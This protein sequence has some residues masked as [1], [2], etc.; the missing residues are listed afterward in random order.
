MQREGECNSLKDQAVPS[1]STATTFGDKA[2]G[3][4]HI[5]CSL[6]RYLPKRQ[7]ATTSSMHANRWKKK[8]EQIFTPLE[9]LEH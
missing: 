8:A 7:M 5:S 3:I 2:S 4:F 1:L 9:D 6:L